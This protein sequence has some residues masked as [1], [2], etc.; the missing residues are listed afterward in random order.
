LNGYGPLGK[1]GHGFNVCLGGANNTPSNRVYCFHSVPYG[2]VVS[3]RSRVVGHY[4]DPAE[5]LSA[6]QRRVTLSAATFNGAHCAH[7][8]LPPFIGCRFQATWL[9]WGSRFA[10]GL[11]RNREGIAEAPAALLVI[12]Q[13]FGRRPPAQVNLFAL[14]TAAADTVAGAVLGPA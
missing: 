10:S 11:R 13:T 6:H 7:A 3:L 1:H 5:R 4:Y 9:G 8:N 2:N 14:E 12:R